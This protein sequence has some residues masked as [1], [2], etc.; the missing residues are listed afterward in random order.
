LPQFDYDPGAYFATAIRYHSAA[1][2]R[3]GS[4]RIEPKA[5]LFLLQRPVTK[6]GNVEQARDFLQLP[7]RAFVVMREADWPPLS[8]IAQ[9]PLYILETGKRFRELD[10]DDLIPL[11]R[12]GDDL[13][14]QLV[15]VSNA[16]DNRS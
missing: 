5:L 8:E 16:S 3:V 4:M 12:D 11:W 7:G 9:Q 1:A 13:T 6:I 10:A 2:D 14:E 15:L